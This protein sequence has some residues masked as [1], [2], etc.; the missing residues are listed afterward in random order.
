MKIRWGAKYPTLLKC[1]TLL[2]GRPVLKSCGKKNCM[3]LILLTSC[4]C[5]V[6]HLALIIIVQGG[7]YLCFIRT[8]LF[9]GVEELVGLQVL[10]YSSL[11][12]TILLLSAE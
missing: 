1:Q 9:V 10:L 4:S 8:C 12:A 7:D 6:S 11:C 5:I 2:G 3:I